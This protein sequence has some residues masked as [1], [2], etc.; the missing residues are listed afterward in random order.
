VNRSGFLVAQT[1]FRG[2]R[3]Q[4]GE[5]MRPPPHSAVSALHALERD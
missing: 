1:V 3:E 5:L 2:A 4:R